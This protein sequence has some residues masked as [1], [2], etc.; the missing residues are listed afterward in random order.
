M[1]KQ[2]KFLVLS[3]REVET[4]WVQNKIDEPH[5]LISIFDDDGKPNLPDNK[6]R[7]DTLYLMF[8]DIDVRH[9]DTLNSREDRNEYVL[10]NEDFARNILNFVEKHIKD[11]DLIVVH[12]HAGV[13]RSV[14]C[15][16]ALSK[17]LNNED[18]KIFKSGVPNI[19]VYTTLLNKFWLSEYQKLYPKM[20]TISF[21]NIDMF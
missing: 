13:C 21:D 8:H 9:I 20:N 6:Y 14:A 17:I 10:F 7:K 3:R 16:S 2:V 18:D 15:A 1:K 11:I 5:I 4:D 12:C 19:L